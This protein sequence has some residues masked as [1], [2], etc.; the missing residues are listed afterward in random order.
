[1]NRGELT[2]AFSGLKTC[3]LSTLF[4]VIWLYCS[5][6]EIGEIIA[7][8]GVSASTD[9]QQIPIRLPSGQAL[10]SAALRSG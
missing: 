8:H 9:K 4:F 7:A 6:S 2:D 1:M 10:H 5:V 3:Q